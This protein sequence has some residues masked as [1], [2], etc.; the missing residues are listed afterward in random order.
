MNRFSNLIPHNLSRPAVPQRKPH[1]SCNQNILDVTVGWVA[2]G[3]PPILATSLLVED[4]CMRDSVSHFYYAVFYGDLFVGAM[5]I[6]GT[7][8][9]AFRTPNRR[10]TIFAKLAGI[11]AFGTALFPAKGGGC[12]NAEFASRLFAVVN[13]TDAGL[14]MYPLVGAT[15]LGFF[16][17]IGSSHL[18]HSVFAIMLSGFLAYYSLAVFTR[19]SDKDLDAFGRITPDKQRLNRFFKGAATAIIFAII[20]MASHVISKDVFG[21]GIPHWD[22][23][24][25]SFIAETVAMWSFGLSWMI[26]RHACGGSPRIAFPVYGQTRGLSFMR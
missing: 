14:S 5:F 22:D 18:L 15:D 12:E 20:A 21:S 2:L 9:I 11:G 19:V 4:S 7:F 26:H 6:I 24:N 17:L 13:E 23:Y 1:H 10:D 3:L 8:L 25:G 16:Q